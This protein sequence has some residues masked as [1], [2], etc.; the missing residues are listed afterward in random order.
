MFS[1]ESD[2]CDALVDALRRGSVDFVELLMDYGTSLENV[3]LSNLE[4]L[5]ASSDVCIFQKKWCK[6]KF[7]SFDNYN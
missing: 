6:S 1:K 2:L 5:Y 7:F 4:T 3:T